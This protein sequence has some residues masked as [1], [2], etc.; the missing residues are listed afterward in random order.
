MD[1]LRARRSVDQ[2]LLN[3][4]IHGNH[5]DGLIKHRQL[6]VTP[7]VLRVEPKAAF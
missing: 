3:M 7:R 1:V 2:C 6:G 5:L 4:S